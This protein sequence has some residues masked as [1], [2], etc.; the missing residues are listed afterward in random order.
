MKI[1]FNY[2]YSLTLSISSY[3]GCHLLNPFLSLLIV[4]K[5]TPAS[6]GTGLNAKV[7]RRLNYVHHQKFHH[8][9]LRSN[10][11]IQ[12]LN[13]QRRLILSDYSL[14]LHYPDLARLFLITI[15]IFSFVTLL[16]NIFYY[17]FGYMFRLFSRILFIL[18]LIFLRF[19]LRLLMGRR[20]SYCLF[21]F[22]IVII[23]IFYCFVL[24]DKLLLVIF[25]FISILV[26]VN[27][28][29]IHVPKFIFVLI[30]LNLLLL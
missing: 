15:L 25:L 24:H 3:F 14:W 22:L 23:C 5:T 9:I 20:R 12:L 6:L 26:T 7:K 28:I 29:S 8:L 10:I 21:G 18:V 30:I 17:L 11:I 4:H 13:K 27:I 1:Q 2:D 19:L 16:T